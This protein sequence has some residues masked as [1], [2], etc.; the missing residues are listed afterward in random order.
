MDSQPEINLHAEQQMSD[1]KTIWTL[2]MASRGDF[3][4][5]QIDVPG[6]EFRQLVRPSAEFSWFLHQ[7]VGTDFRWG[8]RD[9]WGQAEWQ[10]WVHHPGLETWVAYI[11]GAPAGYCEMVLLDDGS[12][13]IFHFG[14]LP[15]FIGQGLGGHFL[16]VTVARAWDL[17]A[18]RVW[19]ST[20]SHDHPHARR[21]YLA[22]GFRVV[23]ETTGAANRTRLPVL[24]T[25]GPSSKP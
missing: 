20:C 24:F 18:N 23:E 22:R 15:S 3:Q 1:Q 2:E 21:N 10:E 6:F 9:Q 12:V 5:K 17:G 4:P 13:R 11:E 25:S 8:G 16:S 7:A 19:L 14:L